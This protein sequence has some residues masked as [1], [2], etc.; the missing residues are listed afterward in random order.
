MRMVTRQREGVL[1]CRRAPHTYPMQ[2]PTPFPACPA[3]SSLPGGVG[4]LVEGSLAPEEGV[5]FTLSASQSAA[6]SSGGA[7]E[8]TRSET[9]ASPCPAGFREAAGSPIRKSSR[10]QF[11]I[12]CLSLIFPLL[13]LVLSEDS[14]PFVGNKLCQLLYIIQAAASPAEASQQSLSPSSGFTLPFLQSLGLRV[15]SVK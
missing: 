11:C 13:P 6:S 12:F 2:H 14:V 8:Q 5:E 3:V 7:R 9:P 10:F 15:D 1:V 4:A